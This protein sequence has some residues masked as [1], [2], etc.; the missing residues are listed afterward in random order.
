MTIPK[1]FEFHTKRKYTVEVDLY[2]VEGKTCGT[3]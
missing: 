2:Q 1:L 3:I